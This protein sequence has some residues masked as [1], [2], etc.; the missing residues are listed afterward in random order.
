VFCLARTA[1]YTEL[2]EDIVQRTDPGETTLEQI[3]PN[4]GGEQY[5]VFA[6]EYRAG[7]YAQRQ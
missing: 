7:F 5:K 4:E 2:G 1:F 6:N 3:Q